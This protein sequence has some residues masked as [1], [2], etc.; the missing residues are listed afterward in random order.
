MKLP[1]HTLRCPGL[2]QPLHSPAPAPKLR[3]KAPKL[4][5]QKAVFAN[6]LLMLHIRL[7][8]QLPN[9]EALGSK[10]QVQK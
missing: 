1:W 8:R 5:R 3:L 2:A 7:F 10:W 9:L 4:L 6:D